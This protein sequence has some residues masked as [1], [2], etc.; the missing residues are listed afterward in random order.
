MADAQ[1]AG[2]LCCC[3]AFVPDEAV[4]HAGVDA[5]QIAPGQLKI[6]DDVRRRSPGERFVADSLIGE[7]LGCVSF[8]LAHQRRGEIRFEGP[9]HGPQFRG[10]GRVGGRGEGCGESAEPFEQQRSG[11]LVAPYSAANLTAGGLELP[12]SS[13]PNWVV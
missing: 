10:A 9:Q 2:G 3:Q 7:E 5:P 13:T 4:E 8:E 1:A 12:V 11:E 6:A